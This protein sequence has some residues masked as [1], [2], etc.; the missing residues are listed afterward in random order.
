MKLLTR[1]L[2]LLTIAS[3][4]LFFANCGGDGGGGSSKQKTQLKKLSKVWE[5]STVTL[6]DDDRIADFTNFKLTIGGVYNSDS[7]N[8]PYTY[9]VQGNMPDPSPWPGSGSWIFNTIG[10]NE[11]Q[12]IRDPDTI[13]QIGM[14]YKIQSD[15]SL[16]IAFNVQE[17]MGWRTNEVSGDWVFVFE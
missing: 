5:I 14:T 16:R 17:G 3:L 11:G 13:D 2:S 7:P 1:T 8:G 10:T 12:I 9:S 4:A 15:G 6:N